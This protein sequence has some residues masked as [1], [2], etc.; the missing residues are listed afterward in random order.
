MRAAPHPLRVAGF[1]G[2]TLH[3]QMDTRSTHDPPGDRL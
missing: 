2:A 3:R 1:F